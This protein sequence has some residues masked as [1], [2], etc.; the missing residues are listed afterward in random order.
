MTRRNL[1]LA[2]LA[3]VA[4]GALADR[5]EAGL[6][7]RRGGG[8]YHY[9]GAGGYW[10][11][12]SCGYGGYG[13]YGGNG[14]A[15]YANYGTGYAQSTAYAGQTS[16]APMTYQAGST[17]TQNWAGYPSTTT[18]QSAYYAPQTSGFANQGMMY[19]NQWQNPYGNAWQG[20]NPSGYPQWQGQYGYPNWQGGYG[21][22]SGYGYP[23]AGQ[24]WWGA[25]TPRR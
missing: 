14:Q 6:F 4:G 17:G 1:T 3:L 2:L 18:Y 15:G 13:N 21:Y 11:G 22:G 8:T 23:Q 20:Y 7:G 9:N 16:Y 12:G 5:A 19:A 25:G 10:G 24:Q